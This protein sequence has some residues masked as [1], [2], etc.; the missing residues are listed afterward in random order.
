LEL[1]VVGPPVVS[2]AAVG[3]ELLDVVEARAVAPALAGNV[4]R[5]PH[6]IGAC[7]EVGEDLVG[8]ADYERPR[9]QRTLPPWNPRPSGRGGAPISRVGCPRL[10]PIPRSASTAGDNQARRARQPPTG[11]WGW[12][13]RLPRSQAGR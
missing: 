3:D 10:E 7:L 2:G 13:G 6:A 4:V 12:T 11:R 8:D 9:R 5:P 1:G